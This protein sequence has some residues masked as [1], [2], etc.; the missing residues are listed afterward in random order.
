[1]LKY[2]LQRLFIEINTLK[3]CLHCFS[4]ANA[5]FNKAN[6][7][8]SNL[9]FDRPIYHISSSI[10]DDYFSMCRSLYPLLFL[11]FLLAFSAEDRSW[12]SSATFLGSHSKEWRIEK[13][14]F[15][16]YPL[17][18]LTWDICKCFELI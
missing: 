16:F 12:H 15:R 4:M 2:M 3:T 7:A 8:V 9:L 11:P 1:M 17:E 14:Q 18:S 6:K 13:S 5:S 10:S